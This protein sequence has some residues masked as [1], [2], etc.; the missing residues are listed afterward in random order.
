MLEIISER[1]RKYEIEYSL[2]Y[3]IDRDGGYTF[4]CDENGVVDESG[5]TECAMENLKWCRDNLDKFESVEVNV[6]KIEW[7][8]PAVGLCKCGSEVRLE[9][10]YMGACECECCGR[11][12]NLFGQELLSPDKWDVDIERW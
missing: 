10:E 11:W 12:Y 1:T 6:R 8:E 9:D 5:L 7:V 2:D 4:P 3:N